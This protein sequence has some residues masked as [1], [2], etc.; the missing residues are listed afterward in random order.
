[1]TEGIANMK[2][3]PTVE[4]NTAVV[5]SNEKFTLTVKGKILAYGKNSDYFRQGFYWG[6]DSNHWTD[7]VYVMK[8]ETDSF[9]YELQ[10]LDG[11]LTYYWRAV[12]ENQY[13]VGWGKI[14]EYKTPS[15]EPSV[16]SGEISAFPDDGALLFKGE[17]L[18]LG[19]INEK[20]EKGFYW[21]TDINNLTDSVLLENDHLAPG[22]F[23]Y[24]LPNARGNTIY[25][26]RAFARNDYGRS[27]GTIRTY[28][29]PVIFEAEGRFTGR[30]RTNFAVFTLKD[31]LYITCGDNNS[32]LFSDV[33]RYDKTQWWYN[34][35]DM[36]GDKRRFPVAFTIDDS[37]AY[38]GT[39]QGLIGGSRVSY[40]DFYVFNGNT[41]TWENT[42][43]ATPPEM[44]R[45]EAVAFNLNNKGYVVG[46][47]NTEAEILS[48]VWEYSIQNGG[49]IWR[50][51]N[52]FPK[53][54]YGGISFYNEERI[55][56]GFGSNND[57]ENML[58][59]YDTD[60]DQ[61][62]EFAPSPTYPQGGHAEILSGL[63]LRDK[64]YLLDVINNIWEL[65]LSTKQYRQK[66]KLPSDFPPLNEQYMLSLGDII[67]IGLGGTEWFYR[68]YP[69]WDN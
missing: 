50:K 61:W 33:C 60:N 37:L 28:T 53:L 16:V 46:G 24:I 19:K 4:T 21:G 49:G 57:T 8:T 29:T 59:E 9:S 7:P 5:F 22:A 63:I 58:W 17:V 23:S 32:M 34:I 39:G 11:N 51:M 62:N 14:G 67:Y 52:N 15:E 47:I 38:V 65:N 1:M 31:V 3:E 42:P 30:L 48:D 12:A 43:V 13:G 66:S 41:R 20:F 64:I 45:H 26:W 25:Y 27:L 69:L 68:Y 35:D 54:F 2:E 6:T 44:P 56:A 10:N 55:F 36:P 40:G 18:S